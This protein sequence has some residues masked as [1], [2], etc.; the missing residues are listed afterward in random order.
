MFIVGGISVKTEDI[1]ISPVVTDSFYLVEVQRW[2]IQIVQTPDEP[3]KIAV[4]RKQHGRLNKH[5]FDTEG[6]LPAYAQLVR[7]VAAE[8]N[9]FISN[10]NSVLMTVE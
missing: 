7:T 3:V 6:R 2:L 8:L 1:P 5:C 10:H 4:A 9:E